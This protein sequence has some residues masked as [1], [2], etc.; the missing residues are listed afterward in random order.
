MT[1]PARSRLQRLG[2]PALFVLLWSTGFV[3]AQYGLP[4]A[5][6]LTFLGLRM[7]IAAALLALIAVAARAAV[8]SRPAQYG[9]A[10]VVGLL[11]HAGYLGGVFVAISL[12]VPSPVSA[13]VVSL[14]P[15]LTVVLAGPVLGERASAR[16]WLGLALGVAGVAVVVWPG[17]AAAAGATSLSVPGVLACLVALAAGTAGTVH[18]KRFG[19]GIPLLWGT[20]VQYAAAAVVLL[21]GAL[22]TERMVIR[23][24]GDFVLAMVWLV[25]AL[26]LGAV[27][28]LLVL[29][30]RGTAAEVSSLL[31]LVPPAVALEAWLL[32]GTVP[33]AVSVAGIA[34]TALGVALVVVPRRRPV[35][36][37]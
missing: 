12:G 21:A 37:E 3:G 30:R 2:A 1:A 6:P 27:L 28:L 26:S 10:A 25:L 19:G 33:P 8:P 13:V 20:A 5:E 34:L 11:L 29:L 7:V 9:H 15:V 22:A 31:Y 18:Q 32:F 17:L 24:T 23:W 36:V 4:Y 16:Q 14:Q 35:A